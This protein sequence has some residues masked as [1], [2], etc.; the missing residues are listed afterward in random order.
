MVPAVRAASRN[1]IVWPATISADASAMPS[2]ALR[3]SSPSRM[4]RAAARRT[5]AHADR[6]LGSHPGHEHGAAQRHDDRERHQRHRRSHGRR[7]RDENDHGE[8][9]LHDLSGGA[10]PCDGPQR[11]ADIAHVAT[12]ADPAVDVADDPA[13]QRDVEEQRPVVRGHRDR[14]RQV[15]AQTPGHGLPPPRAAHRGQ[16]RDAGRRGQRPAVDRAD[17]AEKRSRA[18]APDQDG[19]HQG[20]AHEAAPSPQGPA[21]AGAPSAR[22]G[23]R[24][25]GPATCCAAGETEFRRPRRS[26]TRTRSSAAAPGPA[27]RGRTERPPEPARPRS[28]RTRSRRSGRG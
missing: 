16:H 14:Q 15:D 6:P 22:G 7:E 27:R 2:H 24:P 28:A 17:A 11:A 9:G 19:E 3:A 13:G 26:P 12:V 18:Q 1:V 23:S 5:R 21:H 4:S 8:D 10:L 20:G 25:G